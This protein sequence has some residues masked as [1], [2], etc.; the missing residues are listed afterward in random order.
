MSVFGWAF[1]RYARRRIARGLDGLWVR[2]LEQAHQ[3][4]LE[5]PVVFAATHVAWWDG[6]LLLPLDEGLGR[7]G[8]VWMDAENLQRLP[9]FARLGALPLHRS[10]PG[11]RSSVR[12]ALDWLDRPGRSLWVFPQGEQRPA[13]VRPLGLAPGAARV[14]RLA[15]ARLVPVGL[16]YG[17]RQ[18]PA[19]AAVVSLGEPVPPEDLE[20][21]LLQELARADQF[22]LGQTCDFAPLVP[23]R[24][25][26]TERSLGAR[27]LAW[28]M[29]V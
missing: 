28:G 11:L 25:Q 8:R 6:L 5:G 17:F 18:A 26:G 1:R 3:Q 14:A 20:G 23:G 12:A 24:V 21:G 7:S 27:L 19:P 2:G 4:V 16:Q 29:H 9:Y 10:G 13:W 15:G 22:L